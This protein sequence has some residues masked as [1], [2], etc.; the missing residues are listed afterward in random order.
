VGLTLGML[1]ETSLLIIRSNMPE[2]LDT[3][4]AHLLRE[5]YLEVAKQQQ[6]QQQQQGGQKGGKGAARQQAAAAGG[7]KASR[8]RA[9]E[10]EGPEDARVKKTQ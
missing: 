4:Y 10:S 1:L 6:Q 3:R 9:Q 7:Q 8:Q 2:S 5:D